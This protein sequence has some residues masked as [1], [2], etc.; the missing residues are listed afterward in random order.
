MKSTRDTQRK[1]TY[2]EIGLYNG[3]GKS[4]FGDECPTDI[5]SLVLCSKDYIHSKKID[6]IHGRQLY[7]R[8]DRRK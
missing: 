2:V 8:G 7:Y 6:T 5:D 1:I 3:A 4:L